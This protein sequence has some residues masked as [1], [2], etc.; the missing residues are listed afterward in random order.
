MRKN[1]LLG[2]RRM[3]HRDT[4][5]IPILCE[6]HVS[7]N[8]HVPLFAVPQFRSEISRRVRS[9]RLG[10]INFQ[11]SDLVVVANGLAFW[12]FAERLVTILVRF[13]VLDDA[14]FQYARLAIFFAVLLDQTDEQIFWLLGLAVCLTQG[15]QTILVSVGCDGEKDG[16]IL[17]ALGHAG[18]V[19][20]IPRIQRLDGQVMVGLPDAFVRRVLGPFQRLVQRLDPVIQVLDDF[21]QFHRRFVIRHFVV[22]GTEHGRGMLGGLQYLFHRL[23]A[24]ADLPQPLAHNL[25]LVPQRLQPLRHVH[26]AHRVQRL[27][28]L[29]PA[30]V[31]G[32][33]QSL[34]GQPD[35]AA[36]IQADVHGH[37]AVQHVN[38]DVIRCWHWRNRH[39]Q[40]QREQ[41]EEYQYGDRELQRYLQ[42]LRLLTSRRCNHGRRRRRRC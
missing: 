34:P 40:H 30:L 20:A 1:W 9:Q 5:F 12:R 8:L 18:Q 36:Q 32:L 26:R 37:V 41:N 4:R 24:G 11:I 31:N 25:V 13:H 39:V 3:Q 15:I 23:L 35:L 2:R 21:I 14:A 16:A 38:A 33:A 28:K 6:G 7:I 29:L 17:P 27:G 19:L 22:V 42:R 10:F